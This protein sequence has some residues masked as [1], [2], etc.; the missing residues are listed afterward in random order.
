[1]S[2][3]EKFIK[4]DFPG[5]YVHNVEIGNGRADS[6]FMNINKQV[7]QFAQHVKSDPKLRN[8]FNL[9]G[10]SQGGNCCYLFFAIQNEKVEKF[11]I[12]HASFH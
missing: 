7:E 12:G 9:I 4:E 5:I 6:L 8:G 1:M 2:H 11:R 3:Y 10:H